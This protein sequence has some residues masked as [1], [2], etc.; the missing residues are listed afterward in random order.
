[1]TCTT[2]NVIYLAE[3]EK[4]GL[5]GVGS[6]TVWKPRLRNY[7]SWVKNNLRQCRIANHFIDNKECRGPTNKPWMNMKFK[8]IDCL[9][10]AQDLTTENLEHELLRK[11]QFW[12]RTL[13]TYHHGL[14]SSHDINRTRRCDR[15]RFE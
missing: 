10:N 5:Q 2:P 7:K 1:M 8:I 12:I 13:L 3:C 4:C 11:E 15:E 9:D 14:N 6:T